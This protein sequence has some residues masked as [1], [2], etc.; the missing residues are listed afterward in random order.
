MRKKENVISKRKYRMTVIIV[1][2][3]EKFSNIP[4]I[5]KGR[6]NEILVWTHEFRHKTSCD[7]FLNTVLSRMF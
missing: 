6:S 7:P 2:Q 1:Y 4:K 3:S 5:E